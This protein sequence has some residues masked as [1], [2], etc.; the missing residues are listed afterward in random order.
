MT[1]F[2]K[3]WRISV[4]PGDVDNTGTSVGTQFNIILNTE[5]GLNALVS[6]NCHFTKSSIHFQ[7]NKGTKEQVGWD[8]KVDCFSHFV[9]YK[10]KN[11]LKLIEKT[12]D[13][14][15]LKKRMKED[16]ETNKA[17][18]TNGG[19]LL[20]TIGCS[21]IFPDLKTVA[22]PMM[23]DSC[24]SSTEEEA[25]DIP[26]ISSK[27]ENQAEANAP[28]GP[29]SP[30]NGEPSRPCELE[31]SDFSSN[32]SNPESMDE[33]TKQDLCAVI[34]DQRLQLVEKD[35]EIKRQ[36]NEIRLLKD[37]KKELESANAQITQLEEKH[38]KVMK[39]KEEL[40]KTIQ[41]LKQEKETT[42]GQIKVLQGTTASQ[43][44][45]IEL[46]GQLIRD[47]QL[48]VAQH[49][50]L[51]LTFM[52]EVYDKDEENERNVSTEDPS[53]KTMQCC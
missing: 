13:F 12:E 19:K 46:N 48:K 43:K 44:S 15:R 16:L 45:T 38:I 11:A 50:S 27:T 41:K 52:D 31:T 1:E 33:Q 5:S 39:C 25:G 8:E 6:M 40:G 24:P 7:L 26:V 4:K 29:V 14:I 51:A 2:G 35:L 22:A 21:S 34:Q 3:Q 18:L 20:P 28:N 9:T 47:L 23:I 42:E 37:A 32:E 36:C 53:I 10:F 49:K 30:A 17:Q